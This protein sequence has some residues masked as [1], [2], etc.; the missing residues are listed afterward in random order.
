M[1]KSRRALGGQFAWV[2]AGRVLAA[3]IQAVSMLL[4]IRS[5][6]PSEFGVFSAV[7]GLLALVQTIFDVGLPTLVIRE[8][9]RDAKSATV[10][11][12]LRLNDRL[13]LA[14]AGVLMVSIVLA[15]LVIAPYYF[16]FAPLALWAAAERNA[17]VWLGVAIAD[18]DAKVNTLNLVLRRVGSL[19]LFFLLLTGLSLDPILSFGAATAVAACVSWLFAHTFV[20]RRLATRTVV[21]PRVLLQ[22]SWPYWVNSAATQARNIDTAITGIVAGPVQGGFYG[23]ASRLTTPL[24]ILPTSLASVLL[25][26]AARHTSA[27][28]G[29]LVRLLGIVMIGFGGFYAALFAAVPWAV[30]TFLGPDYTGAVP[31][32][33]VTALGLMFAAGASLISAPLQGVGLK[34]FVASVAVSTTVI[35]LIGVVTGAALAG[36]V[37]AAVGLAFS[38]V[39]QSSLLLSRLLRF[40]V[41]KEDN[42]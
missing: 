29:K 27:S 42:R 11:A 6:T 23:A 41:K 18:G 12:A 17:D 36:A 37:G 33:Q 39:V 26:A 8:R 35:C 20:S 32:L 5:V 25:P 31:A 3:V 2:S 21:A 22:Q 1:L 24:R 34:K 9:A 7:Y 15:G 4:L 13:A 40:I 10:G 19:V 16:V 14:M 38:Y 28:L 30:P